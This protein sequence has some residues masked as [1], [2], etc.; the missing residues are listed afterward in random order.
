MKGSLLAH[1]FLQEKPGDTVKPKHRTDVDSVCPR[2]D[3]TSC[4]C[5]WELCKCGATADEHE[6]WERRR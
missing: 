6:D 3:E 4:M 1:P 5:G 2:C